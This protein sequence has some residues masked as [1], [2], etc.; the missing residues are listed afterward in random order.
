MRR[1]L[2]LTALACAI[3]GPAAAKVASPYD[4]YVSPCLV[5]CPAGDS[6]VLVIVRSFSHE[7][8]AGDVTTL[9]L[10]GCPGVRLEAP[11]PEAPYTLAD[12]CSAWRNSNSLGY[13]AFPLEAGGT[14]AGGQV[15]VDADGVIIAFRNV[16][17]SFDQNGD[18][19]VDGSDIAAVIDKIGTSDSTAD[20]NCDGAVTTEDR[21]IAMEHLGHAAPALLAV[22]PPAMVR[23]SARPVPNPARRQVDFV[24]NVPHAGRAR[25]T[26]HDLS[27]RRIAVVLDRALE[28]GAHHAT[29]NGADA[30]GRRVSP[31]L[32][33][34]GFQVND[35]VVRGTIV[36][37]R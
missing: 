18:W 35:Q 28:A 11:S 19:V 20:F 16:V 7:P 22:G 29:W 26:V 15:V 27:G 33:F 13:A 34:Y 25:L 23:L 12:D 9:N 1:A 14:C 17:A 32:Y 37:V 6:L 4:S 8:E 31:G 2:L 3:A 36:V 10:C 30:V 5:T 24:L 21:D